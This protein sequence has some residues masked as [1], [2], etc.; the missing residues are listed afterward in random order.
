VPGKL[1]NTLWETPISHNRISMHLRNRDRQDEIF[2]GGLFI[3]C[4]PVEFYLDSFTPVE[5][6]QRIENNCLQSWG[7]VKNYNANMR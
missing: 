5:K 6:Q 4:S 1:T 3:F 7:D 2:F